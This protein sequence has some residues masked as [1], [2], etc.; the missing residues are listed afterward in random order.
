MMKA[1]SNSAISVIAQTD[2]QK[3]K[4]SDL[5]IWLRA[6]NYMNLGKPIHFEIADK[7][8]NFFICADYDIRT[9]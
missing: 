6:N 5:E 1:T 2:R 3:I 8:F 9:S 4:K 7:H